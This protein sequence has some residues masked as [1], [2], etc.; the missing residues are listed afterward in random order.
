M[1]VVARAQPHGHRRPRHH[2]RRWLRRRLPG[3]SARTSA[4]GRTSPPATRRTFSTRFRCCAAWRARN[5]RCSAGASWSTAAAT[6]RW[7]RRAPRS[8]SAPPTPIV[9]Y[10]RTRER[11]P[12]HDFEVEEA[13]EEGVIIKWLSTITH[14]DGGTL[15]LEKMELDASGFPQPTG[16]FEELD[17]D[18]LVLALGQEA[19]LSLLDGCP[20]HRDRGSRRQGRPEHD[21]RHPGIF[22]GGD[23]V[24]AE[25]TVTVGD[26]S[27][28]EGRTPHRRVAARHADIVPPPRHELATFDKLNPWYY[29]DAPATV[30]PQLDAARRRSTFDEVVGGLDEIHR[31]VRGAPLPLVR[32]LLRLRQLLRRLPRQ[33]GAQGRARA[34]HTATRSTLTTA[35]DAACAWPSAR[36][37]RS[38]WSPRRSDPGSRGRAC[39]GCHANSL[40]FGSGGCGRDTPRLSR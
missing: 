9:V 30:R 20:G 17:A 33:R 1:G 2:A 6:R 24:P 21:D 28:Q 35:R 3:R 40:P 25:R 16:E 39:V 37:A 31:A 32:Q 4:S 38:R 15:Q 29:T 12:A 5:R 11:M 8:G 18:S 36:A 19:D 26:R 13:L 34:L 22:A 7:M 23:M 27:R 14:A 10:R